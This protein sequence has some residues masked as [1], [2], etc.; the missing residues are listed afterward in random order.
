MAVIIGNPLYD[1]LEETIWRAEA[2]KRL[3]NLK[4]LDGETVLREDE[5]D[6]GLLQ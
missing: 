3:H 4:K 1:N 5:P 2:T 6:V